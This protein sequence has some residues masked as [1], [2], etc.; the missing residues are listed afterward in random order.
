M[1][2]T[3]RLADECHGYD[4]DGNPVVRVGGPL[5]MTGPDLRAAL[6]GLGI[7]QREFARRIGVAS[8]TVNRW[9]M[10][11]LAVP[12][13]AA[14]VVKLLEDV[15]RLEAWKAAGSNAV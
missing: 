4:L 8:N 9:V 3:D 6:V 10:G 5:R 7:T 11:T 12:Q 2:A 14:Y 1:A 15:G 13:Y